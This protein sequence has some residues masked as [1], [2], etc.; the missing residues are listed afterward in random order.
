MQFTDFLNFMLSMQMGDL[1][2]VS[3]IKILQ[4]NLCFKKCICYL[5]YFKL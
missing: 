5:S 1:V 2:L 3:D 4:M